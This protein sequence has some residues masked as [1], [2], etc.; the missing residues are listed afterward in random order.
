M[1]GDLHRGCAVLVS[2]RERKLHACGC[3]PQPILVGKVGHAH[4]E[5]MIRSR[6]GMGP[7]KMLRTGVQSWKGFLGA[8]RAEQGSWVLMAGKIQT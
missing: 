8:R 5:T 4:V 2:V 6:G 7:S 3:R 1:P